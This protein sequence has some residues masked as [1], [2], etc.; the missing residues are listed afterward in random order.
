MTKVR[1]LWAVAL[2][3]FVLC[4]LP[5]PAPAADAPAKVLVVLSVTVKGDRQVYLDKLKTLGPGGE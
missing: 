2:A 3:T 5:L 4:A 1:T